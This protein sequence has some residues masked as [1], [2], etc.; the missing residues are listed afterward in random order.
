MFRVVFL[1]VESWS[2]NGRFFASEVSVSFWIVESFARRKS[3]SSGFLNIGS[4]IMDSTMTADGNFKFQRRPQNIRRRRGTA[5]DFGGAVH[6]TDTRG[7][8]V[9]PEFVKS[10]V[11]AATKCEGCTSK[12]GSGCW[13]GDSSGDWD[14]MQVEVDANDPIITHMRC[15]LRAQA[16]LVYGRSVLKKLSTPA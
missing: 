13:N 10:E 12:T 3:W 8:L 6:S 11:C 5:I 14:W 9:R 15:L 7:R 2:L 1:L 16:T 4:I